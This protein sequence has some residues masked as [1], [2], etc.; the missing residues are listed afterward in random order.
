MEAKS[1]KPIEVAE[2]I[3]KLA[4]IDLGISLNQRSN[5]KEDE[6]A[7]MVMRLGIMVKREG[8]STQE[9]VTVL[10]CLPLGQPAMDSWAPGV[11]WKLAEKPQ[12]T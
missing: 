7:A 2:D 8:E 4:H 9:E 5:E 1:V 6:K 12:R 3:R 11:G 10:Q